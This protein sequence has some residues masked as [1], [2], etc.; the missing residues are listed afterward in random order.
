MP[1]SCPREDLGISV[2]GDLGPTSA[3]LDTESNSL[4]RVRVRGALAVG[5]LHEVLLEGGNAAEAV[6]HVRQGAV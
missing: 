6:V 5:A 3:E 4:G 1:V 2:S